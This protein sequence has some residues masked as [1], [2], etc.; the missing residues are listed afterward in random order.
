MID[1]HS[2]ILPGI[3]DGSQSVSESVSLLREE[4]RQGVDT[5]FLT[6]HFYAEEN[7][8]VSFLKKR[9][10]AWRKL[11]P[12]LFPGLPKVR[13][14]TEVQYFEGICA[15]EDIRHLRIVGTDYIL[16]E[17]PFSGWSDRMIADVIELEERYELRVILAHIER[18][19]AKQ[20]PETWKMLRANGVL[21][22][23]NV[24]FFTE[25]K[26]R[27]QAL[28]MLE[29]KE[30]HFLGSDC[31]NMESRRPNWDALPSQAAALYRH[32]AGYW[33]MNGLDTDGI[34]LDMT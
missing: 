2:H 7:D 11:E 16:L 17:M 13:L 32:S 31:H 22:Q 1:I 23:S 14:G 28:S 34:H 12:C 10:R 5:V 26:T 21:M 20:R 9:Y 6:P 15:V 33:A 30:I 24:S 25:R 3:D 18:Y 8:P 27:K 4:R 29:R 19:L